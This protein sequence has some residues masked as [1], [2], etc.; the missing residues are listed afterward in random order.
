MEKNYSVSD[1]ELFCQPPVKLE[2]SI[3]K[4]LRVLFTDRFCN[5]HCDY[6]LERGRLAQVNSNRS[7]WKIFNRFK[8]LLGF[9][10]FIVGS[11]LE[12][13]LGST[14]GDLY[15]FC[16][17]N[18]DA[19]Y[20][21]VET[22]G[23]NPDVQKDFLKRY[24]NLYI[25]RSYRDV[26]IKYKH[27]NHNVIDHPRVRHIHLITQ[28][29]KLSTLK[30]NI[31]NE[32]IK[33]VLDYNVGDSYIGSTLYKDIQNNPELFSLDYYRFGFNAYPLQGNMVSLVHD[34]DAHHI[35]YLQLLRYNNYNKIFAVSDYFDLMLMKAYRYQ[36]ANLKVDDKLS[37]DV[38][39]NLKLNVIKNH[40]RVNWLIDTLAYIREIYRKI[41]SQEIDYEK[42]RKEVICNMVDS[43]E[44]EDYIPYFEE[45]FGAPIEK[46]TQDN[47]IKIE[48]EKV[49]CFVFKEIIHRAD[50]ILVGKGK[51]I[52]TVLGYPKDYNLAGV[53]STKLFKYL[54]SKIA[55]C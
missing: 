25:Y 26:D 53:V 37:F 12:T 27:N 10:R 55:I 7:E 2:L 48:E 5:F 30:H 52:L 51:N 40:P 22:N 29:D 9:K 41:N 50:I 4:A 35:S 1:L 8:K 16:E 33:F 14:I 24:P 45:L 19:K 54:V 39:T 21:E 46:R 3:V 42:P 47:F 49:Y 38:N 23:S 32:I 44:Q 18:K 13:F 20:I 28:N 6:C 31:P 11:G 36:S 43:Q 15:L 17:Q 34:T